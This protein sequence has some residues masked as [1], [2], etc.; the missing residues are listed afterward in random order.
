MVDKIEFTLPMKQ[1]LLHRRT[2]QVMMVII[3]LVVFIL[4]GQQDGANEL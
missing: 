4:G 2:A 1:T 3:A